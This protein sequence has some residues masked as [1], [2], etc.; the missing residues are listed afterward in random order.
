MEEEVLFYLEVRRKVE[1]EDHL[2]LKYQE[3]ARTA[4]EARMEAE[5]E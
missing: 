3:E 4:E 5:E 1:E 2:Q